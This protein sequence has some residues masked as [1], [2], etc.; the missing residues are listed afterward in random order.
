MPRSWMEEFD[1]RLALALRFFGRRR[2]FLVRGI[3]CWCI[4]MLALSNDEVQSYDQRFQFRGTQSVASDIVI[5]VLKA[6]DVAGA[7]RSNRNSLINVSEIAD[8]TDGFFWNPRLWNQLLG[9]ILSQNPKSVG[10]SLYFGDN[11]GA[12]DWPQMDRKLFFDPRVIWSNST[13]Y[14]DRVL[15]PAFSSD[16]ES[17][18]G[19]N[20]IR[21]DEDGVVRRIFPLTGK[22]H[23]LEKMADRS[24]PEGHS[25]SINYR[26]AGKVIPHYTVAEI[27]HDEWGPEVLKGKYVLIG[28]D[29]GA[30]LSYITP[31]GTMTRSEIL[32]QMLDNLTQKRWI[33][34]FPQPVYSLFFI[35]LVLMGILVITQYPQSVALIFFFW[36]GTLLTALSAWVFDSYYI[37]LPAFSPFLVLAT[38]WV[39]FIG[40]Q[41]TKIE[42]VNFQL[43]QEQKYLRELEQLKNN[44]VSLISHDLK[45]PIAKIQAIVDR[46]ITEHKG[47]ELVNDLTSL[48][49][50]SEELNRYIQSVLKVLRVESRDFK[51]HMQVADINEIIEEALRQLRPLAVEKEINIWA[52]LEPMFSLEF[53]ITLIKEV[54]IN[55]VENAIKYTPTGGQITVH[56][57]EVANE[58]RIEVRDTGVGISEDEIDHVWGKFTR[59]KGQDLKTK[60]TGLGLY[61]VKY[62]IELHGGH[63]QLQSEVGRG[64]TVSFTLPLL[65]V[66][67]SA[68]EV[69]S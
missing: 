44:F 8:L 57:E 27:L 14:M 19:S 32:A 58:I 50:S 33:L 65:D 9:K 53:D 4:G 62:F 47:A 16:D 55:L 43:K 23:L 38:V 51:L 30:G 25:L 2:G 29:T 17:N 20:E 18:V 35:L 3:I 66:T 28:S 5:V 64:S 7:L 21:R 54:I 34:R 52:D 60:G 12:H 24:F 37:W 69:N 48:R 67:N 49:T 15:K 40:Y 22:E 46:L 61:L 11:I 1:T 36:I 31:V 59:G 6:S 63:V 68:N 39:I 56:S 13:N 10:V 26:G 42:R 45:T 41:A